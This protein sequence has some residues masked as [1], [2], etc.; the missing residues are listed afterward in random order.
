MAQTKD[1]I[2][3]ST[4]SDG[5][6]TFIRIGDE[7]P[8]TAG[9][10]GSSIQ[11]LQDLSDKNKCFDKAGNYSA[12]RIRHDTID[13]ALIIQGKTNSVVRSLIQFQDQGTV[14]FTAPVTFD[15]IGFD[16]VFA[17]Q[18]TSSYLYIGTKSTLR[19]TTSVQKLQFTSSTGTTSI[20]Y[21]GSTEGVQFPD[22]LV[23]I[24]QNYSGT[25]YDVIR[26]EN[27]GQYAS[28]LLTEQELSA[29][30]SAP[31]GSIGFSNYGTCELWGKYGTGDSDWGIFIRTDNQKDVY[32]QSHLNV[33]NSITGSGIRI[34]GSSARGDGCVS[35][36]DFS[37]AEGESSIASG[38]ASHAEGFQAKAIGD[39][40]HA[41][42]H[43]EQ[44][45]GAIG[46]YSHAEGY[47]TTAQG[48]ASH[49]EGEGC[50][51]QGAVSH[52]EGNGT[53]A[54]GYAS[55]TEGVGTT[56]STAYQLAIGSYNTSRTD[57]YF[58]VGTGSYN[59]R[60][61]GFWVTKTGQAN[62]G[63]GFSSSGYLKIGSDITAA[64]DISSPG[65]VPGFDPDNQGN[66]GFAI[67]NVNNRYV[68]QFDD[69]YVRGA[70]NVHQMV[71]NQIRATNGSLWVSD[72]AKAISASI[73]GNYLYLYFESGSTLPFKAEDIIRSK[74]WVI[75]PDDEI[76]NW[77]IITVVQLIDY[78]NFIVTAYLSSADCYTASNQSLPNLLQAAG[79]QWVR[80]GNLVDLDRAGGIYLTSG[81]N[82][83]PYID[84]YDGV[85]TIAQS[86]NQDSGS[87]HYDKLKVRLGKLQGMSLGGF[88]NMSGYG[89]YSD[90]V[91]LKG[92]ISATDGNLGGWQINS[93]HIYKSLETQDYQQRD[94]YIKIGARL[95]GGFG[96]QLFTPYSMANLGVN[97][98]G[99]PEFILHNTNLDQYFKYQDSSIQIKTP[100]F[101]LSNTALTLTGS[102]NATSGNF[103]GQVN[104]G[105]GNIAGWTISGDKLY[106]SKITF[107]GGESPFI[108][109]GGATDVNTGYGLFATS[110]TN[111]AFIRIGETSGSSKKFIQWNGSDLIV[112]S[113]NF[114]LS[115]GNLSASN[116]IIA[117]KVTA[118]QGSI[119]NWDI[120][121]NFL[122]S[123]G[124]SIRTQTSSLWNLVSKTG[125]DYSDITGNELFGVYNS[126]QGWFND[127]NNTT[128]T[129]PNQGAPVYQSYS[130]GYKNV[131]FTSSF[132]T[133]GAVLAHTTSFLS[134]P[135]NTK[136]YFGI[137]QVKITTSLNSPYQKQFNQSQYYDSIWFQLVNGNNILAEVPLFDSNT[138]YTSRTDVQFAIQNDT[139]ADINTRLNLRLK[140]QWPQASGHG[141][142]T[143]SFMSMI[144]T[145]A[146]SYT[147]L[148]PD[149]LLV[150]AGPTN[151]IK[152]STNKN[153]QYS[154]L[155]ADDVLIGGQSIKGGTVG[156]TNVITGGSGVPGLSYDDEES[157][158]ESQYTISA[159]AFSGDGYILN[160]P[161]ATPGYSLTSGA[162]LGRLP[163]GSN[164]AGKS[165]KQVLQLMLY[166]AAPTLGSLYIGSGS[167]KGDTTLYLQAGQK[168]GHPCN[169]TYSATNTSNIPSK[170]GSLS[171]DITGWATKNVDLTVD[172]TKNIN[173]TN[174]ID[175]PA[176]SASVNGTKTIT[177][178]ITPSL[179]ANITKTATI[180]WSAYAYMDSNGTTT[181]YSDASNITKSAS[182]TALSKIDRLGTW[183]FPAGAA[184]DYK[185]IAY[186]KQWGEI[187]TCKD[188]AT[189]LDVPLN[190]YSGG[191]QGDP[192]QIT[193][194]MNGINVDYYW[195]RTSG[196]IGNIALSVTIT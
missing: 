194:V 6:K 82:N 155:A 63:L 22:G 151:F 77:D 83:S 178:K 67:R 152:I 168:I 118:N 150:W 190:N 4:S 154:V 75:T 129:L 16:D 9:A 60:A 192:N 5:T 188:N 196:T 179:G 65:Y 102:I 119:A 28:I 7:T 167:A 14:K 90:N 156:G 101:T 79:S 164:V 141:I 34:N 98:H 21:D 139:S 109:L 92:T 114:R 183:V 174:A 72:A 93:D 159:P 121:P 91:Y 46:N 158:I 38:Y 123:T 110:S 71:I 87:V 51:A 125:V 48:A 127:D 193:I 180:Q 113:D 128:F 80:I 185:Y 126:H 166:Y 19:G 73:S 187:I 53:V 173:S 148:N 130:D 99:N 137:K 31:K 146:S 134:I 97:S 57:S 47:G 115:N 81:D 122:Q 103:T 13:G 43:L 112:N 74:R 35:S 15:S 163:K 171:I 45:G 95:D 30:Y 195:Y 144:V 20:W 88:D 145:T 39:Y 41:E 117:G 54:S 120:K 26:I 153:N 32:L 12:F 86:H 94:G 170:T 52:A 37:H 69:L 85:Q 49:A 17:G 27:D 61:D 64:Q 140:T 182:K 55:H 18:I 8:N 116:V 44:G 161:D 2:V 96:Y 135:A 165:V 138:R 59:N 42:G 191:T 58:V 189:N 36:G 23:V 181:F 40:S 50:T 70:M 100:N 108:S 172:G 142:Y 66:R 157:T 56:T 1:L 62:A 89:L 68:A 107:S 160:R 76:S 147:E 111:N 132:A 186:P 29:G 105:S 33:N 104:A 131:I 124:I 11:F 162:Y 25:N 176:Y 136:L 143:I 3:T 78:T 169:W 10:T 106:A 184:G 149:G 84:I 24:G 133:N 177:L 175:Y